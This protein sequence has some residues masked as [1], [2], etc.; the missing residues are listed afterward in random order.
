MVKSKGPNQSPKPDA[1]KNATPKMTSTPKKCSDACT[2]CGI[3]LNKYKSRSIACDLCDQ[4]FCL[5]CTKLKCSIFEEISENENLLWTC[6]HCKVSLPGW[7]KVLSTMSKFEE[8]I[9][10]LEKDLSEVKKS[11]T[12]HQSSGDF[13]GNNLQEAVQ[14]AIAEERELESRKLNIIIHSLPETNNPSDDDRSVDNILNVKLRCS[15]LSEDYVFT[16]L[17]RN[18][19]GRTNAR[20][21]RITVKDFKTKSKILESAKRLKNYTSFLMCI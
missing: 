1:S 11:L 6:V 5:K 12:L 19:L 9:S 13:S 3:N 20:P 16:R 18:F 21:I 4:W 10:A 8:R 7:Q 17:G 2:D 14:E 15:I